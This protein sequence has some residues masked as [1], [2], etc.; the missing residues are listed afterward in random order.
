MIRQVRVVFVVA[1]MRMM[2]QMIN[3]K[4][5]RARREVR[6]IGDDGDHF[7]P[8]RVPENQVMRRVMNDDVIG[9]ISECAHAKCNQQ[10]QPPITETQSPHSVRDRCL[11]DQDRDRDQRSP[12]ITHHQLPY[13]RVRFDDPPRPPR[14]RLFRV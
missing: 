3:A 7:V 9:M 2:F 6:Q 13:F 11:H 1:L 4:P 5:H 10:A 12:W 14:M 8:A